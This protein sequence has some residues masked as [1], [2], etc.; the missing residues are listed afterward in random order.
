MIEYIVKFKENGEFELG[1]MLVRCKNCLRQN[2]DCPV[3][4]SGID[5]ESSN[6]YCKWSKKRSNIIDERK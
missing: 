4:Y 6:G 3:Q 1:E 5:W 2:I